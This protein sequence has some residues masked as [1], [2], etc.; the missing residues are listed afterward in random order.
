MNNIT[1]MHQDPI[2]A[3]LGVTVF[4]QFAVALAIFLKA[5]NKKNKEIA[6]AAAV[7]AFLGVTEPAIY[8]CSLKHK[9]A[10][11]MSFI[12][13]GVGG[14]IMALMNARTYA[15]G[16]NAIFAAPL[17]INPKGLDSSFWAY[18]IANVA[19][20]LVTL[21]LVMM[22]GYTK[23]DDIDETKTTS[24]IK[25]EAKISLHD[26]GIISPVQ[27]KIEDLSQVKDPV[28]ASG[29]MGTGFAVVP[30]S[31]EVT[32][33]LSGTISTVFETKHAIGIISSDGVEL[34][35]HMG[36]DTVNLKGK[37]F[38]ILVKKGDKVEKGQPIAQV[39]WD[40]IQKAG[41]DTTTMVI[42]TNSDEFEQIDTNTSEIKQK[43]SPI[44]VIR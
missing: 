15:F 7:T 33:P 10:F 20:V 12:G 44:I 43:D 32:A 21:I 26:F 4:A 41:Y 25:P 37:Y 38:N 5:K 11:A 34:L 18:I 27:G 1:T 29:S 2:N 36:I 6:G 9:K 24:G 17:Y 8:G 19:T 31:E 22:F 14:A 30:S 13:G 23:Q 35:I 28:F 42:V 16:S 3:I 39:E 40:K